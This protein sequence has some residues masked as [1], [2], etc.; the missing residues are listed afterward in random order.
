MKTKLT[1]LFL[2]ALFSV[3]LS[4]QEKEDTTYQ[5]YSNYENPPTFL[6]GNKDLL[7]Y[8]YS[9]LRYP[10]EA[11]EDSIQGEVICR[12]TVDETGVITDLHVLSV[13]KSFV[14]Q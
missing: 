6:K 12:F 10:E 13:Q 7:K 4:A 9:E 5:I 3:G 14:G 2:F 11:M 1:L 8:I